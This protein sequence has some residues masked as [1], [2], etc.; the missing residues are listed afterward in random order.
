MI[1]IG[2]YILY[3]TD[4]ALAAEAAVELNRRAELKAVPHRG[5]VVVRN[6]RITYELRYAPEQSRTL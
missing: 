1:E 6:Q 2:P 4:K 3:T 5:Y